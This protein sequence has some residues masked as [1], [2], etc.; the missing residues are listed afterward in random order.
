MW[1]IARPH[2]FDLRRTSADRSVAEMRATGIIHDEI[3]VDNSHMR[4][5]ARIILVRMSSKAAV[6]HAVLIVDSPKPSLRPTHDLSLVR[7]WFESPT[8]RGARVR[9]GH[10]SARQKDC[11]RADP[12][13]ETVE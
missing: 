5:L 10:R 12:R 3:T 4:V 9:N 11:K 1:K 6:A 7:G 8:P 13:D 2:V